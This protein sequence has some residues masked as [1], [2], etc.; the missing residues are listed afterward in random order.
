MFVSFSALRAGGRRGSDLRQVLC[1]PE[2]LR[3]GSRV[4]WRV[5]EQ[6]HRVVAFGFA[7]GGLPLALAPPNAGPWDSSQT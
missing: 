7:F 6:W 5:S 4:F 1:D 2:L 3:E